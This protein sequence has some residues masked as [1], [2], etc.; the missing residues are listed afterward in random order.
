MP[1]VLRRRAPLLVAVVVLVAVAAVLVQRGQS[2]QVT[3]PFELVAD[4]QP[5]LMGEAAE[6]YYEVDVFL[7]DVCAPGAED[8]RIN[9]VELFGVDGAL[10]LTG[11]APEVVTTRCGGAEDEQLVAMIQRESGESAHADGVVVT[12]VI[13]GEVETIRLPVSVTLCRQLSEC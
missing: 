13:G 11:Y 10:K 8:V 12:Y 7:A 3:S 1:D 6:D 2:G 4:G 5:T 9:D